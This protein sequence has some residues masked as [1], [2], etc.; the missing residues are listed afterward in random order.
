MVILQLVILT[1]NI[2]ILCIVGRRSSKVLPI[3]GLKAIKTVSCICAV[4]ILSYLPLAVGYAS[5]EL[6]PSVELTIQYAMSIN[7]IC[8]PIIYSLT[9]RKFSAFLTQMVFHSGDSAES[10]LQMVQPRLAG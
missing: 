5:N 3:P 8:N 2:V 6:S 10:G 7:M 1:T 4:Y 9:N